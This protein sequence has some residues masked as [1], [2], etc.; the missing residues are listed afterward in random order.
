M[1]SANDVQEVTE[2][3]IEIVFKIWSVVTGESGVY[4]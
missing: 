2:R 1:E 3:K 4:N